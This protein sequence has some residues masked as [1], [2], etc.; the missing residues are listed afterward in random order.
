MISLNFSSSLSLVHCINLIVQNNTYPG[1]VVSLSS[2]GGNFDFPVVRIDYRQKLK[3]VLSSCDIPPKLFLI[4][5]STNTEL[6]DMLWNLSFTPAYYQAPSKFLFI[7]TNLSSTNLHT[8]N[9]LNIFNSG[10]LDRSSRTLYNIHHHGAKPEMKI[11]GYCNENSTNFPDILKDKLSNEMNNSRITVLYRHSYIYSECIKCE[12]PGIEIEIF[13]VLSNHLKL[14]ITFILLDSESHAMNFREKKYDVIIGTLVTYPELIFDSTIS[15]VEDNIKLFVPLPK[16]LPR[17]RL[18]L[19]IFTAV[20]WCSFVTTLLIIVLGW[21]LSE[22]VIN[23]MSRSR[24]F[25]ETGQFFLT[26][27]LGRRNR[28]RRV[29]IW[30]E[31]L[32]FNIV[33]LSLMM[34]VFFNSK[35]TFLLYGITVYDDIRNP[36]DIADRHLRIGSSTSDI[37]HFIKTIQGLENYDKISV[38]N[39]L[40]VTACRNEI[41]HSKNMAFFYPYRQMRYMAYENDSSK[42]KLPLLKELKYSFYSAQIVA[43]FK[44]GNPFFSLFNRYLKYMVEGGLTQYIIEK[45]ENKL[46]DDAI[47]EDTRKLN[48]E[49]MVAPFSLLAFGLFLSFLVFLW[50]IRKSIPILNFS[51]LPVPNIRLINS[52]IKWV[53]KKYIVK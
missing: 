51:F 45:Y 18:I 53:R 14:N 2:S 26:F 8:M 34:N 35:L 46:H 28:F 21:F 20:T 6:T 41:R 44:K 24:V 23:R 25:S 42:H 11:G 49:H 10:F 33:F 50:E 19:F 47:L 29:E 22:M 37:R 36:K 27:F 38:F 32:C 39:C 3:S 5:F 9:F 4:E 7:G 48:F 52:G 40:N 30:Q 12:R 15:Y 13:Q 16:K 1:D 31:I 43:Y 17:W